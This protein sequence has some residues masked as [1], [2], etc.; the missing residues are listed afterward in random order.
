VA[1]RPSSGGRGKRGSLPAKAGS[2]VRSVRP[3]SRATKRATPKRSSGS[4]SKPRRRAATGSK[5]A[6]KKTAARAVA[7]RTTRKEQVAKPSTLASAA[8][9]VRGA[10]AG[11]VVA[12]TKRLPWASKDQDVITLLEADH[13]RFE[14]LLKQGED[15][16]ERAVKGRTGLLKTLSDQLNLHELVEEKIL[17]PALKTNPDARDIVLEG[18][19]EHHIADVLTRELHALSA[20]DERWG[21]K[22]K[23]LK[24][25]LEHHIK[26][27]ENDM[28]RKARGIFSRED[29]LRLGAEMARMKAGART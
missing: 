15:T 21:A 28:F 5:S 20:D 4:R 18:Y 2:H 25:S 22:F 14:D 24:E 10:V 9:T 29:L 1:K 3:Q 19:E 13:R 16:T 11:A 7:S 6:R 27:E 17:Y 26:E 12:V 8:T 23:V